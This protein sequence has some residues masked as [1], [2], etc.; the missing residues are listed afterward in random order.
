MGAECQCFLK[1]EAASGSSI[2]P[3]PGTQPLNYHTQWVLWE[4]ASGTSHP[5][6][7]LLSVSCLTHSIKK[8]RISIQVLL[9]DIKKM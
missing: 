1:K 8:Q 5:F 2:L 6:S 4:W 3:P 7:V 9:S